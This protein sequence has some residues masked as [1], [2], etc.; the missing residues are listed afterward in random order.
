MPHFWLGWL[1]Q[2]KECVALCV[3]LSDVCFCFYAMAHTSQL[4]CAAT[5]FARC[6]LWSD[7]FFC[8]I[9]ILIHIYIYYI[10]IIHYTY[11]FYDAH[12]GMS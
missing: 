7:V 9:H 2:K 1:E 5:S 4:Y 11:T 10:H 8:A 6:F 12:N 3:V